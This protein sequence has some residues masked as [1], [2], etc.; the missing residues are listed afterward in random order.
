M[1]KEAIATI[2]S[3]RHLAESQAAEAMSEIMSGEATE[4]QIASFITALRIKG[5]TVEEITGCTRVMRSFGTPIR[6]KSALDIDREDITVDRE[7][8]IDTCGTGGDGTNTFNVST[9]TALVVAACGLTVAKHG[10]RSVSS[11]CGSADVLEALGVNVS[12]TPEKV[13]LCLQKAGIGFLFA[14][15]LHG[16]M[17][18]AAGPR[19]QIGIRTIFNLLGPLTNPAAA[20]CQVLGVYAAQL[21]EPL[22][23]VLNNLGIK[24]AWVVHGADGVDEISITDETAVAQL[25]DGCVTTFT[26]TPEQY[27]FKRARMS[28]IKGGSARDNA[29]IIRSILCGERGPRRNIVLFNAAA[30]LYVGSRAVS[31]E[32]AIYMAE[33][34]LDS[35]EAKKK[36]DMLIELTNSQ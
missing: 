12:V 24:K 4:A 19:K 29:A 5:E 13:E 10:N 6:I 11:A 26:I 7:T 36:L 23:H 31:V 25:A 3:G 20:N 14:P 18:Y 27:G 32:D 17:K 9:V 15:L 8:I 21:V 1:I 16:S 33:S 2:V 34:A 28:E 30:G 35:G 22:A